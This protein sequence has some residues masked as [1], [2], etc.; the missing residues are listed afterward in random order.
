MVEK[1]FSQ[2]YYILCISACQQH[3][4]TKTCTETTAEKEELLHWQ[5][6]VSS[7]HQC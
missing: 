3:F 1:D 2:F 4:S 6:S 5:Q 7:L